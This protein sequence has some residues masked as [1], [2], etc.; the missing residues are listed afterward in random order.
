M[1]STPYDGPV[2]GDVVVVRDD[3]RGGTW[4]V[5]ADVCGSGLTAAVLGRAVEATVTALVPH[6]PGPAA[7]LAAADAALR[8]S[9]APGSFV[10]ALAVR[11]DGDRLEVASAGHPAPVLLGGGPLPVEP[12]TPLG[13]ETGYA[14]GPSLT[15]PLPQGA[16]LL[17]HTDGL[18][19]RVR[20]GVAAPVE[21][22]DLLTGL[23]GGPDGGVDGR[24]PGRRP[25]RGRRGGARGGRARRGRGRRRHAAAGPPHR[26]TAPAPPDGYRTA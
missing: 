9:V 10:T 14:A 21:L 17:L 11:V 23:R 22:P 6:V 24:R 1:R 20:D 2:G 12:G 3:G 5:V 26:L 16:A 19:D 25:G 7:L 13:L 8:P 18:L 4:F 15:A